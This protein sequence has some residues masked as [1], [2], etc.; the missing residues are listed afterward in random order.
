M[1]SLIDFEWDAYPK[2]AQVVELPQARQDD[3]GEWQLGPL[4]RAVVDRLLRQGLPSPEA[5]ARPLDRPENSGL[6]RTFASLDETDA[7]AIT[8]FASS[9]GPLGEDHVELFITDGPWP[10][11]DSEPLAG[12]PLSAWSSHIREMREAVTLWD[13]LR[14]RSVVALRSRGLGRQPRTALDEALLLVEFGDGASYIE[15]QQPAIRDGWIR[16]LELVATHLTRRAADDADTLYH[17]GVGVGLVPQIDGSFAFRVQPETLLDAMWL[18]L[19]LAIDGNR[20]YRQCRQCRRWY[21][22]DPSI[23]RTNR[24]YCTGACRSAYYRAHRGASEA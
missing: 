12:E 19:A 23:A 18:Q 4:V 1:A 7:E 11:D 3:S 15:R 10:Y 2:G 22:L 5:R 20:E 8:R 6:F 24:R 14:A 16:L 13:E 9:Y 21:E 17:H